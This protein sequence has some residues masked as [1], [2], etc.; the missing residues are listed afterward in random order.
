MDRDAIIAEI[1]RL[2]DSVAGEYPFF[3][4]S[5]RRLLED[6]IAAGETAS[7]LAEWMKKVQGAIEAVRAYTK[8]TL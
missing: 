3:E 8:S 7:E 6:R 4:Q 5:T 1:R 2:L